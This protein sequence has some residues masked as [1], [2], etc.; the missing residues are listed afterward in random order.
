MKVL[1]VDDDPIIRALHIAILERAEFEV[2]AVADGPSALATVEAGGVELVL[3]DSRMP[4]MS[5]IEVLGE[6]RASGFSLPVILV[7]GA[8]ETHDRVEGLESGAD[9]YIT[10][11]VDSRELL[12]RVRALVR[13]RQAA[14]DA[15]SAPGPDDVA[16]RAV[17]LDAIERKQYH[18]VFQ[19]IVDL[20][21]RSVVAFEALTRFDDGCRPDLRFG[22]AERVGLGDE[23]ALAT[24]A[25]SI[26]EAV[27]LP[28]AVALHLN[29]SPQLL[30]NSD[31]VTLLAS[32]DRPIVVEL[33]EHDPID[34]YD[35]AISQLA[36][37]GDDIRLAI[38]DAGAGYSSMTHIL[39][40][41]P[42]EV[43]LDREWVR[44]VDVDVARQALIAGLVTFATAT[45]TVLVAEGVETESE[46]AMLTGLGVG[47]AQGYHLGRPSPTEAWRP[48]VAAA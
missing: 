28:P 22:E 23:L 7:T 29:V 16:I 43:K 39:A 8:A 6:L 33:T 13:S 48:G 32:A 25:A 20:E 41:R 34:D 12:A 26:R 10:K 30:T 27:E 38:D 15:M 47:H 17:I 9:D 42:H 4:G 45:E 35:A 31:L 46:A 37:L 18:P 19:P 36:A 2:V 11:P 24:L 5:G 3:L 14:V 40:L 1:V 21:T 44:G